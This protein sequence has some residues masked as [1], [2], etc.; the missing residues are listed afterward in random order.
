MGLWRL[1]I[2]LLILHYIQC[3][4]YQ[5]ELSDNEE[6]NKTTASIAGKTTTTTTT[7]TT[8]IT[9]KMQVLS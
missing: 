8:I 1:K 3:G 6:T 2:A 9:T 7:T 4:K 5:G